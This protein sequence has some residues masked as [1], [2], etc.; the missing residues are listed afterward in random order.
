MR[1]TP[2]ASCVL[3]ALICWEY[4]CG[5]AAVLLLNKEPLRWCE[6]GGINRQSVRELSLPAP[7]DGP[8]TEM[9]LGALRGFICAHKY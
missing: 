5:R 7:C 1:A 9:R 6:G 4:Y 2:L 3:C 8:R